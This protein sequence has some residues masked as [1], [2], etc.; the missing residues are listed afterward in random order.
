MIKRKE[1]GGGANDQ[2][3]HGEIGQR[4]TKH[5]S[6]N[7]LSLQ[8]HHRYR[9]WVKEAAYLGYKGFAQQDQTADLQTSSRRARTSP[10]DHKQH[11]Q[12][13]RELREERKVGSS[14]AGGGDDR[15]DLEKGVSEGFC[16]VLEHMSYVK[17]N[18]DRR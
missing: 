10:H 1:Q 9:A 6:V 17:S 18:G 8:A 15:A 5:G 7:G 3:V 13:L 11:Q 12:V 4:A 14:K 2:N 16:R